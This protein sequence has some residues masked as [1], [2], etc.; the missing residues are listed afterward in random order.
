MK[1]LLSFTIGSTA[2]KVVI[3][4]DNIAA[5]TFPTTSTMFIFYVGSAT[6]KTTITFTTADASYGA[7]LA[8]VKAISDTFSNG[9]SPLGVY[10]PTLPPVGSTAQLITSVAYA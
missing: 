6:L 7:H 8:V 1:K 3:G 5:I 9:V 2:A 4:I 10:E